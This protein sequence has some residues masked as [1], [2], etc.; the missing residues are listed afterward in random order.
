MFNWLQ[1]LFLREQTTK[2]EK[3]ISGL[4]AF[5]YIFALGYRGNIMDASSKAFYETLMKPTVTP[6]EWLFP[7]VW[8]TLFVL[9]GLAGYH[10]WNFFENDRA[11]KWFAALYFVN[12][13]LIYLWPYLFFTR[14]SISGALYAI[15]A[16]IIVIEVMILMA[17]KTNHKAAYML[18]PYLLWVLFATYLNIS[19]LVLNA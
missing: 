10:V 15:V 17:F 9:I 6:P 12:G 4:L 16:L 2:K 19:M 8:T 5:V 13:L 18:V 1:T 3:I 7:F 11:R 14:H